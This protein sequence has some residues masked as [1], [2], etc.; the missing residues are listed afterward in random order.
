MPEVDFPQPARKAGE[1]LI[2]A[3]IFG[4]LIALCHLGG[5]AGAVVPLFLST[6]FTSSSQLAITFVSSAHH[7]VALVTAAMLLIGLRTARVGL[8]LVIALSIAHCLF[9]LP[10]S[11]VVGFVA[12]GFGLMLYIP[13]LA[14]IYWRPDEFR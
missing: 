6:A 12:F 10:H 5:L 9:I 7:I 4:G 1:A 3:R 2:F 8:L 14:L 11:M 13:P